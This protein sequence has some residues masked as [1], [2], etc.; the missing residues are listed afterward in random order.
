MRQFIN[1]VHQY[2]VETIVDEQILME[3][4]EAGYY[5][6]ISAYQNF[7]SIMKNGLIPNFNGGNYDEDQWVSLEGVYASRNVDHLRN[8]MFSQDI[9]FY[10]L[11]IVYVGHDRS[12]EH[13]SEL[14]SHHDIV[15]RLL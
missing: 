10:T 2:L 9:S 1:L 7:E 14:Q 8:I 6:H 11:V 5:F 3:K 15:C 12:E 4:P 13:T